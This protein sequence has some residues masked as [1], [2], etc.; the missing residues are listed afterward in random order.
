MKVALYIILCAI[1]PLKKVKIKGTWDRDIP[2][3]NCLKNGSRKNTAD[4]LW[5]QEIYSGK[6]L[7]NKPY[8]D[9]KENGDM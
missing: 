5:W 8:L 1:C 9:G 7:L 2:V 4:C 3:R 6:I